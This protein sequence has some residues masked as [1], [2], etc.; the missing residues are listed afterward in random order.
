MTGET[1]RKMQIRQKL[2]AAPSQY[3]I[4]ELITAA[5]MGLVLVSLVLAAALAPS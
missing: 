1:K 5:L 2:N 4:F 3:D